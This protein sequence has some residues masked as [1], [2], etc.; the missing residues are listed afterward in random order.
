MEAGRVVAVLDATV[1]KALGDLGFGEG[2]RVMLLAGE[3]EAPWLEE[4]GDEAIV[5]GDVGEDVFHA[6]KGLDAGHHALGVILIGTAGLHGEH[7]IFA[8]RFGANFE[9]L[10]GE[11]KLAGAVLVRIGKIAEDDV[12]VASLVVDQPL[13]GIGMEKGCTRILEGTLVPF[14]H[15]DLDHVDEFFVDINHDGGFDGVV[16]ESFSERRAFAA[17][18]NHDFLG[19]GMQR[20]RGLAHALVEDVLVHQ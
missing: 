5:T 1:S 6:L 9:V 4:G 13:P 20:H 14:R 3:Y 11:K 12:K 15:V 16:L 18:A 10:A 2:E 17:S 8:H 7:A 19:V